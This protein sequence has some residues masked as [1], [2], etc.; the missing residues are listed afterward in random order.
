[1]MEIKRGLFSLS[2]NVLCMFLCDALTIRELVMLDSAICQHTSR[3]TWLTLLSSA[4]FTFRSTLSMPDTV[5][6]KWVIGKRL[7]VSNIKFSLA[8]NMSLVSEFLR[9]GGHSVREVQF[10]GGDQSREMLLVGMYCKGITTLRIHELELSSCLSDVLW[11]NT[12]I[13]VLELVEVT[14]TKSNMLED[15]ALRQLKVLKIEKTKCG[16]GFLRSI[17]A[18]CPD[19][20][21]LAM[22]KNT[23]QENFEVLRICPK[24]K[25]FSHD[26]CG[27][28]IDLV[29]RFTRHVPSLLNLSFGGFA[30]LD[31]ARVLMIVKNIATLRTL[32]IRNCAG[33]TD[34]SLEHIA[35]HAGNR[36]TVL[37]ADVT[38]PAS[39]KTEAILDLFSSKCT[40]LRYLNINCGDTSLC[41]GKS[42]G[43]LVRGC[44]RLRTLVV[45]MHSTV[46]GSSRLLIQTFRPDL[47]ILVHDASTEYDLLAMPI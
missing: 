14:N 25:S 2:T 15:L 38:A 13:Q 37:H 16:I 10:C 27:L 8:C 23:I 5:G 31:D 11:N 45:N 18:C 47:N 42:T 6:L 33:L 28:R 30:A 7:K 41:A 43:L 46:S 32:N 34:L 19:L 36:I 35:I 3:K 26:C 9:Y 12:N 17:A 4:Q 29:E 24:M 21:T 20:H 1:M 44:P 39:V 40:K 22:A